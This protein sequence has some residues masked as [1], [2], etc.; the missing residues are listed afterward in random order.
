MPPF[1]LGIDLHLNRT[2]WEELLITYLF[3][4]LDE[5]RG[6]TEEWLEEYNS[7]YS[8]AALGNKTS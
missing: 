8:H 4:S 7:I 5:A 3:I 1:Y 6:I 2:Y